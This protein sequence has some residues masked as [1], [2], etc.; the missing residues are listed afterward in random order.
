MEVGRPFATQLIQHIRMHM[1]LVCTQMLYDLF[2]IVDMKWFLEDGSSTSM[3]AGVP[4]SAR[5][6]AARHGVKQQC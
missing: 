1:N 3:R 5:L 4:A 6:P 2:G